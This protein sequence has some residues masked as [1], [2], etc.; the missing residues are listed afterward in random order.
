MKNNYTKFCYYKKLKL[1]KTMK[2]EVR[3]KE[4]IFVLK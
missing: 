1:E 4:V 2:K 3:G